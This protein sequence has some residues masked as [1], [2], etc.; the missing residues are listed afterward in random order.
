MVWPTFTQLITV[1]IES[2]CTDPIT[3]VQLSHC[4]HLGGLLTHIHTSDHGGQCCPSTTAEWV[5]VHLKSDVEMT[6]QTQYSKMWKNPGKKSTKTCT[7]MSATF[8]LTCM[9]KIITR[10]RNSET[11]TFFQELFQQRLSGAWTELTFN[12][13]TTT[14]WNRNINN[15]HV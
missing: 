2:V 4:L 7:T 11:I 14:F 5:G 9:Y 15:S 1:C 12:K 13:A 10:L 3:A 6:V 8:S